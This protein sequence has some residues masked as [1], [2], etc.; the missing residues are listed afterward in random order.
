MEPI[1]TI[2]AEPPGPN[3]TIIL[4]NEDKLELLSSYKYPPLDDE[5]IDEEFEAIM[6]QSAIINRKCLLEMG[7]NDFLQNRIDVL[8]KLDR[9]IFRLEVSIFM[10]MLDNSGNYNLE[11]FNLSRRDILIKRIEGES[12]VP[13]TIESPKQQLVLTY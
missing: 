10:N 5:E 12:C 2:Q 1:V 6:L 7:S 8:K 3:E 9:N 11:Y 13:K 4:D